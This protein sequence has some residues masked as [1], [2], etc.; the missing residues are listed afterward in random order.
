M[1]TWDEG[2][3]Q[4][5]CDEVGMGYRKAKALIKKLPKEKFELNYISPSTKKRVKRHYT[6]LLRKGLITKEQFD[7]LICHR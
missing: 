2:N 4:M 3:P 5:E 1:K 7:S 6:F